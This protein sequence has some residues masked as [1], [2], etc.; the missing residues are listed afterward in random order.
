M[1]T[2][3]VKRYLANQGHKVIDTSDLYYNYRGKTTW[4]ALF[5]NQRVDPV[6]RAWSKE[7]HPYM[8][9]F[10]DGQD[11][12]A[13]LTAMLNPAGRAYIAI[14]NLTG[15]NGVHKTYDLFHN[16]RYARG[17]LSALGDVLDLTMA[18][19][20]LTSS[21]RGLGNEFRHAVKT[22]NLADGITERFLRFVGSDGITAKPA[23]PRTPA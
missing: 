16:G 20:G 23:V 3:T 6:R 15:D 5:G 12:A 13:E 4:G 9:A 11:A 1:P 10:R 7:S 22:A 2:S 17:S 18:G 19:E 8:D 14:R 21:M